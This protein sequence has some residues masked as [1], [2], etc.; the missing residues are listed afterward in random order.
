MRTEEEVVA[1]AA[2]LKVK[3]LNRGKQIEEMMTRQSK[4]DAGLSRKLHPEVYDTITKDLNHL[5]HKQMSNS[6]IYATLRWVLGVTE[7]IDTDNLG[8]N[9]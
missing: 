3:L 8:L 9:E 5:S 7:D 2:Q 1:I 4:S 6:L